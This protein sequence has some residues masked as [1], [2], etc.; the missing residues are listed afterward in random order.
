MQ[1]F[2]E[3]LNIVSNTSTSSLELQRLLGYKHPKIN[4]CIAANPNTHPDTLVALYIDFP[5]EVEN[6]PALFLLTLEDPRFI[7]DLLTITAKTLEAKKQQNKFPKI[8]GSF[9][10]H[11]I[12]HPDYSLRTFLAKTTSDSIV[13]DNLSND[14]DSY[15]LNYVASNKHTSTETLTKLSKEEVDYVAMAVAKNKNTPVPVLQQLTEHPNYSVR[16]FAKK[17]LKK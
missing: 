5:R 16:A 9:L 4:A 13:L 15:V 8:L 17:T 14:S 2:T 6:N 12:K 7:Y 3:L 10:E 1:T 11:A